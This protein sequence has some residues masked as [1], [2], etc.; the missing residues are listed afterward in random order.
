MGLSENN[1][2]GKGDVMSD[3]LFG[4]LYDLSIDEVAPFG[5]NYIP[6]NKRYVYGEWRLIAQY[7]SLPESDGQS[8]DVYCCAMPARFYRLIVKKEPNSTGDI[9][10]AYRVKTGSGAHK[11]TAK[12][13]KAIS[14]G[15]LSFEKE[16]NH[17]PTSRET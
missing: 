7:P 13:A 5:F 8:V 9:K 17:G 10:E 12:L 2:E 11:L 6:S 14:W 16:E 15:M 4:K 3:K 1:S